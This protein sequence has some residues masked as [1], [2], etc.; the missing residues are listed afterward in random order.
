MERFCDA[1]NLPGSYAPRRGSLSRPLLVLLLLGAGIFS[2]CATLAPGS[3][4]I[5]IRTQ[6]VLSNSL[7]VYD[8]AMR[9]HYQVS[10]EEP[11]AVYAALERVRPV[12]PKAWR[13]LQAS[14]DGYKAGKTKDPEAL[15]RAVLAFLAEVENLG[16]ESWKASIGMI[17]RTFEGGGR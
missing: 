16:P 9:L 6:D 17:R 7:S 2:A 8:S 10:R 12:F 5:V 13:G 3:D 4:P 11:P 14:L 15:H 1:S